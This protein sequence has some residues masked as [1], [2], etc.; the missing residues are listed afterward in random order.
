MEEP[1]SGWIHAKKKTNFV[2]DGY[3]I[4]KHFSMFGDVLIL[5]MTEQRI[6]VYFKLIKCI[7]N[8]DADHK[9]R[10]LIKMRKKC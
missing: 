3:V 2:F 6:C 10:P 9:E 4:N 5:K 1:A 8:G 7:E